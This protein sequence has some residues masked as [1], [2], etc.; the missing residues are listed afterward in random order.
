MENLSSSTLCVAGNFPGFHQD[1]MIQRARTLKGKPNANCRRKRE[2]ISD[3]KKDACY[4]EKR[5]KN[6]EAA[7]RSR[8]KRRFNDLVLE[9][10]VLA[11]NEEN[12]RLKTELLQLKL[13]FGLGLSH[14]AQSIVA[15]A[16]LGVMTSK[17]L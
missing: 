8:E 14:G 12:V 7:K 13:R 5:R 2:F 15:R 16:S 10:R 9:N 3:E 17:E 4:W 6:N 1:G 11:L